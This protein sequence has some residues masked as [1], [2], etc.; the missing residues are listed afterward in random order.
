[1]GQFSWLDCSKHNDKRYAILD[2]VHRTSFVLVPPE[3]QSEFG[4][5]IAERCYEG[6][7]VFG[8][9][10]VYELVALWNRDS[11]GI[12]NI[13]VPK[14]KDYSS[15]YY[16][17][18]AV[19]Q[20]IEDCALMEDYVLG[21]LSLEEMD[22]KWG[23]EYNPREWLRHI[24][25][26][27]ACYDKDNAKLKYPIKITYSKTAVYEDYEPSNSDPNQGW[28]YEDPYEEID[29]DE[30]DTNG[31]YGDYLDGYHGV[32]DREIDER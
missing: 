24:G 2:G 21:D 10:D 12:E 7:G 26:E 19:K 22:D 4:E 14:R 9:F 23:K 29:S 16:Y 5:R 11:I 28:G 25:I 32:H 1:M 31:F 3:F 13:E 17:H 18:S 6:Y 27:I 15:D 30:Y 8:G 20:Y